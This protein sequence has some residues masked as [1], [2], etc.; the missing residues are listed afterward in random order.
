MTEDRRQRAEDRGQRAEAFD[1]GLR[2]AD[3]R[4]REDKKDNGIRRS[5]QG[6]WLKEKCRWRRDSIEN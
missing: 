6:A 2:I 5:A 4:G 3:L 1:C